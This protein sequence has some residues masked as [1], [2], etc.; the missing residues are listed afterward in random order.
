MRKAKPMSLV[1]IDVKKA[2]DSINHG[3]IYEVLVF[4]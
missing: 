2:F 4:Q 1:F 3:A